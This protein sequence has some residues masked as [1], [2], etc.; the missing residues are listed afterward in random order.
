MSIAIKKFNL[1][2]ATANFKTKG[3]DLICTFTLKAN[4]VWNGEPFT[5]E[6]VDNDSHFHNKTVTVETV[7]DN[8]ETITKTVKNYNYA[9]MSVSV[10]GYS[11]TYNGEQ[12][13]IGNLVNNVPHSKLEQ[14]YTG[15][16]SDDGTNAIT[17]ITL[18]ADDGFKFVEETLKNDLDGGF[19][20][21]H[22]NTVAQQYVATPLNDLNVGWTFTGETVAKE[23]EII[24]NITGNCDETHTVDGTNVS[25]TVT[26]NSDYAK[27]VGVSV[28]YTDINGETKTYV[29]DFS[30]NVIN[31]SLTDVKQGTTVTLSGAY[32]LVCTTVNSL[33]GCNVT[34]LKPYYIENETVN[35]IATA[36][37]KTHFDA[38]NLPVAKWEPLIGGA[39]EHP[40]VLSNNGKTA[41]LNFTFP[42]DREEVSDST[43]TLLGGTVPD[44]EVTGYGSINVY[45]VDTKTLDDF[46]KIRF[47]K[48]LNENYEYEYYDIGD[49]VNRLHKVY[50]DVPNVSP[51]SLKL[52][53][54]D[55]S[56]NTNSVDDSKVHVD[57]GNVLLP[58][59]SDSGNDFNATIQCFLPFVGFVPVDSDFIGKELNL[60]YDIDLITGYCAF[61]LSCDGITINNGTTNCSSKIIYKTLANDEISTIGDLS[62]LNTVLMGL[63][64][65]ITIKYFEPLNVP[66]NNT[67]EQK[68]I[69]DVTGFAQFEN[70][71]LTT[72]N[73]MLVDEFNEIVSQLA[74]GVYL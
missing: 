73:S 9:S 48:K 57:F 41:T 5:L 47:T 4:T 14:M 69:G 59:N 60:S 29:P 23:T 43:F 70:V 40:L 3:F 54:F 49:Y 56:I 65:Y 53:N 66:V 63:E 20:Y 6:L 28:E 25:I 64:P 33:T 51:T 42:N 37:G 8:T 46:S 34:G 27:F 19:A 68:R 61:N 2:G 32:R 10:I 62:D 24:N 38:E 7:K 15:V 44:T 71:N 74:N 39:E 52:A 45:L 16:N 26:G 72:T 36:N 11:T 12:I 1:Y 55:T 17:R 30:E 31:I 58:V 18:K 50:V 21:S 22:N 13:V 35:V 67:T